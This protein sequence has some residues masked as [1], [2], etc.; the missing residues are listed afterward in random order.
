MTYNSGLKRFECFTTYQEYKAGQ[1]QK[2]KDA[3]FR[4]EKLPTALWYTDDPSKA[5][6]LISCADEVA[7]DMLQIRAEQRDEALTMSRAEDADLGAILDDLGIEPYDFQRAGIAYAMS[8]KRV[9]FGDEPGLGKTLQALACVHIRHAYPCVCVV[10]S[11]IKINWLREAR[12]CIPELREDLAVRIISGYTREGQSLLEGKHDP[13]AMLWIINYDILVGSEWKC[14]GCGFQTTHRSTPDHCEQCKATKD[15]QGYSGFTRISKPWVEIIANLHPKSIII[16]ESH[17]VKNLKSD[18]ALACLELATGIKRIKRTRTKMSEE[19]PYRYL[20]TGTPEPNRPSELEAQ[21]EILGV[22]DLFGGSW[23]FKKHFCDLKEEWIWT[24]DPV[25]KRAK[26][27]KIFHYDGATNCDELQRKLREHVMVRRLKIDVLKD[28]PPK[29]HQC[30]EIACNGLQHFVDKENE[31]EDKHEK[32]VAELK[33]TKIQ[34]GDSG[35]QESFKRAS[36]ALAQAFEAHFSE[37][38][39]LAHECALAKAPTAIKYATEL[40]EGIDKLVIWCHHRDVVEMIAKELGDGR[41]NRE[42]IRKVGGKKKDKEQT[43]ADLGVSMQLR[44]QEQS[45]YVGSNQTEIKGLHKMQAD[46]PR[47]EQNSEISDDCSGKSESE[48]IHNSVQHNDGGHR[49]TG[50]VPITG[51][52]HTIQPQEVLRQQSVDRQDYSASGV[53]EGKCLG[54]K[55]ESEHN[56]TRCLHP[57]TGNDNKKLKKEN[58]KGVVVLY[59]GMNDKE[60]DGAVTS[61][62]NDPSIRVFVGSMHAAGIGITLTKASQCLFVEFDWTPGVMDQAADRI[63]RIGQYDSVLIQYLALE[64]SLDA[65]KVGM[66]N[67]KREVARKVLDAPLKD[68]SVPAD[69]PEPKE[70]KPELPPTHVLA[71]LAR[72]EIR[73]DQIPF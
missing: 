41:L 64:N 37:M 35:D 67:S 58:L 62:Q 16:D 14:K 18:R 5:S 69:M 36:A 48:K 28:L 63:H 70:E 13:G 1:V 27:R 21:L 50:D 20:L 55:L 12:R 34:A 3:G 42:K 25:T 38:S 73:D 39:E 33:K 22:L 32:L 7:K 71:I 54:D 44:G 10:P 66:L 15:T 26:Q 59:G 68:F 17:F 47:T 23:G 72:L 9:L 24:K 45:N 4:F 61:F 51:N 60:K 49:N 43:G 8:R 40:L 30:I 29:R 46:S 11:T 52:T 31:L 19:I 56:Q 6:L 2:V 57:R 53:C 65:K